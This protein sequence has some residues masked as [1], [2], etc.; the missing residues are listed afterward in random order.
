VLVSTD[1]VFTGDG[2]PR[3]EHDVPDPVWDYGRWNVEAEQAVVSCDPRAAIVRL[4]L[5][6]SI[7]PPDQTVSRVRAAAIGNEP[8]AWHDGERR[9]PVSATEVA[10]AIWQLLQLDPS[11]NSGAWHLPGPERLLRRELGARVASALRLDNP[12]ATVP[13]PSPY[14]RPHDLHLTD[15]RARRELAWN[16]VWYS[17]SRRDYERAN[18]ETPAP[19]TTAMGAGNLHRASR[20][21]ATPD[22]RATRPSSRCS[23]PALK[24]SPSKETGSPFS[25][26][27]L[28]TN[29]LPK[30]VFEMIA[31]VGGVARVRNVT[32]RLRRLGH[33]YFPTP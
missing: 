7:D 3:A 10:A 1:A 2:R 25:R 15:R 32:G 6:V 26:T 30:N 11:R 24:G 22:H 12:G 29:E 23:N 16:P 20:G 31:S 9:Q 8:L 28:E 13:A 4:P 5:L 17:R 14:G 19:E 18:H 33:G 27:S 21:V